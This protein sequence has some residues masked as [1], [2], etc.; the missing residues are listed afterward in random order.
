MA[1]GV[2]FGEYR[3]LRRLGVGGMAE[4]FLARRQGPAGFQKDLVIKRILPHL[5]RAPDFVDLFLKEARVA[6]L[7][8]HPNLVHVSA[9]GEIG[10]EY[11]LA[12]EYVD[13][14]TLSQVMRRV[15]VLTPGAAARIA[16]DILEALNAIHSARDAQGEPLG[17][18]HRDV[19]PR[20]VML[21]RD[22]AVK[23]LDFGIAATR[24]EDTS[25]RMGTPRFMSPEQR[26]GAPQ[27]ARSDLY[28]VGLL[29]HSLI[30]GELPDRAIDPRPRP[31]TIPE[32]L[33]PTIDSALAADRNQRSPSARGMQ[34]ELEMFLASR[35]VEGTRTHLAYLLA[36]IIPAGDRS[37]RAMSS[38]A[39]MTNDL[40][41]VDLIPLSSVSSIDRVGSR[42][43]RWSAAIGLA[44]AA[45]GGSL[46][47]LYAAN[48][49]AAHRSGAHAT[50]AASRNPM[51]PP[52]TQA[53]GPADA[54]KKAPDRAASPTQAAK[55]ANRDPAAEPAI[56]DPAAKPAIRDPAAKPAI[57]DPAAKPAIRDPATKPP[58]HE[59]TAE[60]ANVVEKDAAGRSG[61]GRS[62]VTRP[63][64]ARARTPKRSR[65]ANE[66]TTG[67]LTI[68]T[69]P[70]TEVYLGEKRLGMTPLYGVELPRGTHQLRL[71]N[72]TQDLD[73][74]L[75]V[76]IRAGRETRVRRAL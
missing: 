36:S 38:T 70:W 6:A 41:S 63:R 56:R 8:D 26:D 30:T 27:D 11:Y 12:M 20:N 40:P 69:R 50:N 46:A 65:R 62:G 73:T 10:G 35:G 29:L 67:R 19:S 51:L 59:R 21:T 16:T 43:R 9:F 22:G 4:V 47:A 34:A 53:T 32:V 68:D 48:E 28:S 71:I 24:D 57:R 1:D 74:R 75:T 58:N 76:K 18:V 33:W 37:P 42:K 23:L 61:S 2:P 72:P 55:A 15:G 64:R 39:P 5:A 14:L 52:V 3:L 31:T 17:L 25:S 54:E 45:A 66:A 44:I 13:G 7:I 60:N 49:P